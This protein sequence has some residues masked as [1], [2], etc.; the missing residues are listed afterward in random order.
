[1]KI[2]SLKLGKLGFFSFSDRLL[3]SPTPLSLLHKL[4][5]I[6]L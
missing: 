5:T 2:S 4:I 6:F 3:S 1:M